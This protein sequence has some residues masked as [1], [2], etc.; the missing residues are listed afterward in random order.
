[1]LIAE[2]KGG[3][4]GQRDPLGR[5]RHSFP[6][7]AGWTECA[8]GR[9][10]RHHINPVTCDIGRSL[11]QGIQIAVI[12]SLNQP[13]VTRWHGDPVTVRHGTKNG[14]PLILQRIT[15]K[16]GMAIRPAPVEDNPGQINPRGPEAVPNA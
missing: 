7:L 11:K 14:D 2:T 1:M 5:G 12:I 16:A 6:H 10:Q 15:G 8:G 13:E 4:T 3:I 9:H